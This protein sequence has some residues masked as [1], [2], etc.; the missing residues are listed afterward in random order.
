VLPA[1]QETAWISGSL[2]GRGRRKSLKTAYD[3]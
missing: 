1:D 3:R 2:S